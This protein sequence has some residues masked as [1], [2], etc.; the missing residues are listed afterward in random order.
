MWGDGEELLAPLERMNLVA[1]E[2]IKNEQINKQRGSIT[3]SDSKPI[4]NDVIA[5]LGCRLWKRWN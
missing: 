2:L 3:E 1:R 5:K 4:E